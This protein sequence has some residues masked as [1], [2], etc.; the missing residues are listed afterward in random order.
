MFMIVLSL[1]AFI[2]VYCMIYAIRAIT[3]PVHKHNFKVYTVI[4]SLSAAVAY[5][6]LLYILL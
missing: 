3:D 5:G 2:S 6:F 1:L 4:A